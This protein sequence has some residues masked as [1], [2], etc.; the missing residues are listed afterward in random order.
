LTAI[1]RKII[2][3]GK[4]R[5]ALFAILRLPAIPAREKMLELYLDLLESLAQQNSVIAVLI[6]VLIGMTFILVTLWRRLIQ[7]EDK[8]A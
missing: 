3:A 7:C 8:D 4:R 6:A 1:Q 5:R 2:V